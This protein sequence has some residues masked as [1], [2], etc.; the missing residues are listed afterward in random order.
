MEN[1]IC[2]YAISKNE[3]K[4]VDR[5]YESM[6]EADSIVV[7]DTGSTDGTAERLKELGVI[8]DT[9]I[10]DPWRFD[11]ARNESLK[12]VPNDCNILFCTDLDEVLEPGWAKVLKENWI[13]GKHER[14]IYK[15]TWS[16][17]EDGSEGRVFQY[18]KIHSRRWIWTA[19]VHELLVKEDGNGE[20]NDNEIVYLFNDIHLHHYPDKNKSRSS[21]L[22]LLELRAKE[23]PDD[24]YGLIYLSHEYCYR[25][26]YQKSIDLLNRIL[27]DFDHE[28]IIEAS[29]YLFMGDSYKSLYKEDNDHCKFTMALKCY[30]DA[31]NVD[32]TY[33]EP[34]ISLAKI[35]LDEKNY[36]MAEISIKN[37]LKNSFRHYTWLERDTSWSYEPWDLL[38]LATFYSG[39]KLEAIGYATKALS[40][41]PRDE[42]LISNVELCVE[43]AS[44]KDLIK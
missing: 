28:P 19:P 44:D 35:Y 10:I 27:K 1:K 26:H 9:K 40:F 5:W 8:V 3:R 13:E 39:K 4:F 31:I 25:G 18:D 21:Y 38:C 15:Y 32:P 36:N 2:I 30:Y 37:G 20:Y 14:G 29:C 43:N 16:H 42:R 22:P 6:K 7:L 34:Y 11:V 33:I 24:Y 41:A 12:L 17:L 23:K